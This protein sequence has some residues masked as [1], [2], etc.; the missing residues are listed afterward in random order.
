M[1]IK[2]IFIDGF[3][4][5]NEL[6]IDNFTPGLNILF[7]LNE[8]GKSTLLSFIRS[9][10]FGI[11]KKKSYLPLNGK[12]SGHIE[13]TDSHDN[14]ARISRDFAKKQVKIFDRDGSEITNVNL[15][16]H[17]FNIGK[18]TFE[19]VFAFGLEE[20][21]EIDTLNEE[22]VK[23]SLYGASLGIDAKL[24]QANE[25]LLLA[26]VEDI[27]K[28]RGSTQILTILKKEID[29]LNNKI[30]SSEKNLDEYNNLSSYL[31][32]LNQEIAS[33][34]KENRELTEKQKTYLA[35]RDQ[36]NNVKSYLE[37]QLSLN[38]LQNT[39]EFDISLI[40]EYKNKK[41]EKNY[42]IKEIENKKSK[43]E[44][45]KQ[46]IFG[47][48]INYK[49]L[50]NK[51]EFQQIRGYE[52]YIAE[53]IRSFP[54]R[55]DDI[56]RERNR[57]KEIKNRIDDYWTDESLKQFNLSVE[58]KNFATQTNKKLQKLDLE[59]EKVNQRHI[60]LQREVN[61]L[62]SSKNFYIEEQNKLNFKSS[63]EYNK[64]YNLLAK[65][66]TLKT[67]YFNAIN[68][69][70]T[71]DQVDK[72]NKI[73][74]LIKNSK[75][76]LIISSIV[77]V[78][79]SLIGFFTNNV[80]FIGL[81]L[82][83]AISS[84][85]L[86]INNKVKNPE[87]RTNINNVSDFNNIEIE[88]QQ[89]LQEL[90]E[91]NLPE[92]INISY[93]DQL[94]SRQEVRF[95]KYDEN[96]NQ[97]NRLNSEIQGFNEDL[98]SQQASLN[99][100]ILEKEELDSSWQSWLEN[101]SIPDNYNPETYIELFDF[102]D[103]AQESYRK[104]DEL[105]DRINKM[106]KQKVEGEN[107]LQLFIRENDLDIDTSSFIVAINKVNES[108]EENINKKIELDGIEIELKNLQEE[109]NLQNNQFSQLNKELL[110]ILEIAK[111][112]TEEE[113]YKNA[114]YIEKRNQS[115]NLLTK[116]TGD[117]NLKAREINLDL[118]EFIKITNIYNYP[119][120]EQQ[121]QEISEKVEEL[122][123]QINQKAEEV[124]SIKNSISNLLNTDALA[125]LLNKREIKVQE[126]NKQAKYWLRDKALLSLINIAKSKYESEKQPSVIKE[127]G[128][129]LNILTNG[130]YSRIVKPLDG[131]DIKIEDSF[132]RQKNTD[133]LSQGTKEQLYLALRLGYIKEYC[134]TS[135]NIP[136]IFDDIFVNF[137]PDR[138]KAA[139]ECLLELAKEFQILFFTCHPEILSN[140]NEL[141]NK[142]FKHINLAEIK[143]LAVS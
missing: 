28:P 135:E 89:V 6:L 72:E 69:I 74:N 85:I 120:L 18:A 25:K 143:P 65:L 24:L 53:A 26:N 16:N 33:F 77:I 47:F 127:A 14:F 121:I 125:D 122:T 56:E 75:K 76:L 84:V 61:K 21:R 131:D 90:S 50:D 138:C 35:M 129:F 4:I 23:Q 60:D 123:N 20:L 12:H 116:L 36:F 52:V 68:Y 113:L 9:C 133:E 134:Q 87:I 39:F 17:I 66:Q 11:D 108:I 42:L 51:A 117:I 136:L 10:M 101:N 98:I 110:E 100:C 106:N 29:L 7:G 27:F 73:S 83:I 48:D 124:G 102:A 34:K 92:K 30:Q 86:F 128:N 37:L 2:S 93:L 137:D 41:S 70:S 57:I 55:K 62:Q 5:H 1:I 140:L 96:Q 44:I 78:I 119:D 109:S 104:I 8:S 59:I 71:A 132:K 22:K 64:Q 107:A 115:Q 32:N 79:G 118:P 99:K 126:L 95:S 112:S 63:D 139:L 19:N 46:D 80:S 15:N 105:E 31:E 58:A 43:I 40:E 111:V 81:L 54:G 91:P 45:K 141:N 130:K 94:I 88:I 13:F 142:E 3:G 103:K 114:E 38:S 49:L 67:Q 97:L 82:L